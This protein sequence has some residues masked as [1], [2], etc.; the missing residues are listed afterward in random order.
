MNDIREVDESLTR[1]IMELKNDLANLKQE[2]TQEIRQEISSLRQES[3]ATLKT[4]ENQISQMFK[5]MSKRHYRRLPSNTENNP[6]ERANA[7]DAKEEEHEK[8]DPMDVI[9]GI[10]QCRKKGKEEETTSCSPNLE[11]KT[12][13]AS[14]KISM[15]ESNEKTTSENHPKEN[16]LSRD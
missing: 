9:C 13:S 15:K 1:T 12:A 6:K 5:M 16:E 10:C 14:C 8:C 11:S 2:I 3:K 4:I 7:I